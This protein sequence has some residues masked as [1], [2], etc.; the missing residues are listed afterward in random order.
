MSSPRARD[1]YVTANIR[2]ASRTRF[3][4]IGRGSRSTGSGGS[5]VP[6]GPPPAGL[7]ARC[8]PGI[9]VQVGRRRGPDRRGLV[10]DRRRDE[11][12]D[13]RAEHAARDDPD[14]RAAEERHRDRHD[15]ADD[16]G[17]Q[18][19]PPGDEPDRQPDHRGRE[20]DVDP[21]PRRVRDLG[22]DQD[23][24]ERREG[25]RDERRAD[26]ADPVAALV[27]PADPSE[28]ADRQR[29]CLVGQ[30]VR[31]H[32]PAGERDRPEPR[33]ERRRVEQV[34]RV[35]EGGQQDHAGPRESARDV[36]DGR[37]L[38]GAGEDDDAHGHRLD[39]RE[40]RLARRQAIDEAEPHRRDRDPDAVGDEPATA[41]PE[42]DVGVGR[43]CSRRVRHGHAPGLAHAP[44][45]QRRKVLPQV[46]SQTTKTAC[47]SAA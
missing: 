43:R 23:P 22:A 32:R 39:R 26:R 15:A 25:P 11:Q 29:E 7:S 5:A 44:R 18:L 4:L 38:G 9:G 14:G 45:R 35:E 21:E 46:P 41:R 1:G 31:H 34:A 30:E 12:A 28:V 10:R 6:P 36:A 24:G 3:V 17:D 19:A 47:F 27:R 20:D 13:Q 40:A 16:R 2:T 37:E 33:P 42:L 8:V